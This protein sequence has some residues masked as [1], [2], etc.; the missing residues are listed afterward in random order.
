MA[1][2]VHRA[3]MGQLAQPRQALPSVTSSRTA[4]PSR[5]LR[6][7][8]TAS[9]APISSKSL[10][11]DVL[12]RAVETYTRDV[13]A[14]PRLIQHKNEAFWFYRF[15]SIVYDHI[16]NPGHWTEDMR[17]DALS[18]AKIDSPD[19]KVSG[20]ISLDHTTC[21]SGLPCWHLCNPSTHLARAPD[22]AALYPYMTDS[23]RS[24]RWWTWV[25][26]QA[27][28]PWASLS[29]SSQRTLP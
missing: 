29:T 15:L 13:S 23:H 22:H 16:V 5:M 11:R 10:R 27:S 19:L 21:K 3:P 20:I 4:L 9:P 14:T 26:A 24:S 18:V 6:S 8:P 1:Q 7:R 28:A 2:L 25:A 17:T 12:T